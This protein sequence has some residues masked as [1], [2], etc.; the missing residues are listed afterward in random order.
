MAVT[1]QTLSWTNIGTPTGQ[2]DAAAR[3]DGRLNGHSAICND[4]SDMFQYGIGSL[5]TNTDTQTY[6]AGSGNVPFWRLSISGL[7][8][9]EA[10][11]QMRA[12]ATN[13]C[14]GW[15]LGYT[16][17][18]KTN[19]MAPT[20]STPTSSSVTSTTATI[21]CN[22]FPNVL[23]SSCSAQLQ[24]KKSS[25]STWTNAG[26][27][28]ATGGYS[29]VSESENI[30]GL[31]A[32]T[33]YDVRLVISR[34]TNNDTSLTSATSS[35]TTLAGEPTVT[36]N[37]ATGVAGTRAVLNLSL[38]I[39]DGTGVEVYWKWGLA[40]DKTANTTAKQAASADGSFSQQITGLST[41]TQYFFTSFVDFSTPTGSPNNG[42]ELNFTTTDGSEANADIWERCIYFDRVYGVADALTFVLVD[43]DTE[44]HF[45]DSEISFAAGDVLISKDGG[46]L[47]NTTNLPQRCGETCT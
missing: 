11:Y 3:F 17:T 39:N 43:P 7:V 36:T 8:S 23:D 24:Y 19:A 31:T 47:A 21:A 37:A 29:Q 18:Y 33:Q 46:S 2:N 38:V 9:D 5:T 20:A 28:N 35:F 30:T 12:R 14:V 22:Y 44:A 1:C 40:A 4:V 32:S 10:D 13:A 42:S 15:K 6:S 34:T 26:T 41:S 16:Y 45:V 25:D 27:A